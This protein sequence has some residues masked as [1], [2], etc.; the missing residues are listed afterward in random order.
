MENNTKVIILNMRIRNSIWYETRIK[1]QKI[2]EDGSEKVVNEL[3]VV[4]ALSCTE[5]ETSIIDEMSCYISG[6]SAVTSAKKTNYGEILFS[7]LDDDDKWYKAKC[8]FITIDDKS[9]R[10]KRSNVFYLVQAKSLARALRYI[11]E[12]IGKTMID[13]DI[14][15]INE[16]KIYDVFEHKSLSDEA[17]EEKDEQNQ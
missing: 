1:Y 8:Q 5:A 9:E 12:V 6:D 4:D 2:M 15:G 11:D 3:Y 7:D 17:S 10:E 16:T 14:V 13:Y